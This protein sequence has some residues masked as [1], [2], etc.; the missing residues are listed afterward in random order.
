MST[1]KPK[2]KESEFWSS[3]RAQ[4]M[5]FPEIH[6]S[7]IENSAGDGISDVSMCRNGREVWVELKMFKGNRLHFRDSQRLWINART[8][9]GGHVVILAR[10][11][12]TVY[13]FDAAKAMKAAYSHTPERKSFSIQQN[14]LTTIF[15]DQVPVEWDV[16]FDTV[17]KLG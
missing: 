7:R 10:K 11:D 12:K 17:F 1:I 15:V 4:L 9:A 2:M 5:K 6:F 13:V 14:D 16:L 8:K 3:V